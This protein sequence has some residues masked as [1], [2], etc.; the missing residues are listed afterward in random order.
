MHCEGEKTHLFTWMNRKSDP[1][2]ISSILNTLNSGLLLGL[3]G[4]LL[5]KFLYNQYTAVPESMDNE[6]DM[7]ILSGNDPDVLD[8]FARYMPKD[9]GKSE[10]SSPSEGII[11]SDNDDKSEEEIRA[12]SDLIDASD[13]DDSETD[14]FLNLVVDANDS[15]I[16]TFFNTA[17]EKLQKIEEGLSETRDNEGA[18]WL[19]SVFFQPRNSWTTNAIL[20]I[21]ESLN[22]LK[23][24]EGQIAKSDLYYIARDIYDLEERIKSNKPECSS[25]TFTPPSTP[26]LPIIS[27]SP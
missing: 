3:F 15:A 19:L 10:A 14:P 7:L 13:A 22:D 25:T 1:L 9:N 4:V 21:R 24:V 16:Q 27:L 17:N 12:F 20:Y 11:H 6:P 5:I 2:D 8:F 26:L 23:K 18:P